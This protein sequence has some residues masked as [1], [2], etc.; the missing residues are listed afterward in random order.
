MRIDLSAC[1]ESP[2]PAKNGSPEFDHFLHV[3][4][5]GEANIRSEL[6]PPCDDEMNAAVAGYVIADVDR[7]DYPFDGSAVGV[8]VHYVR[9]GG[10]CITCKLFAACS[11]HDVNKCVKH[12]CD[13]LVHH[14]VGGVQSVH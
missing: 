4:A 8:V 3:D 2:A 14:W 7:W 11:D 6:L 9:V 13:V 5:F 10:C 1:Y 12:I